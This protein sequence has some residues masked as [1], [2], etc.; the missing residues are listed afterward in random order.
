MDNKTEKF[1]NEAIKIAE[2]LDM[3]FQELSKATFNL[4]VKSNE[5]AALQKVKS[6]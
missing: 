3:T 2:E 5:L 1:I 4:K 6:N